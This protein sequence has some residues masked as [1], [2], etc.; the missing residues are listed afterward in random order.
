MVFSIVNVAI[1]YSGGKDSTLAIETA[2]EKGWNIKYLLSVKPT[3]K[4]CYLFHYAT[5]EHTAKTAEMLGLKHKLITCNVADPK[6]EAELV[7]KEI[8]KEPVDAVILGGT[9]LQETQLRSI[10]EA[11]APMGIDSFASH[12]GQD[13]GDVL[14]LMLDKGYDICITQYASAG[15]DESMIGFRLNKGNYAAFV[16]KSKKF[17]FHVGGEGGYFDTFVLNAPF[18]KKGFEFSGVQNI[19][20]GEHT[21]HMVAKEL[22][23]KKIIAVKAMN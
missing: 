7:R 3:R 11:L 20:D 15:F 5:V 9:G 23:E 19:V 13:H 6:M 18:F 16:A 22:V 2:M 17:G 10:K 21:G 12:A 8:E 1:L 14:K 4:D